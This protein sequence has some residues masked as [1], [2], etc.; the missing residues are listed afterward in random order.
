VH[1]RGVVTFFGGPGNV[2]ALDAEFARDGG[3]NGDYE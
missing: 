1:G 2:V 3:R